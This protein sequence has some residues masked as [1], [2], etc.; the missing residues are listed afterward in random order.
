MGYVFKRQKGSHIILVNHEKRK[1][2]VV[3]NRK[4][5]PRGT[6]KAIIRESGLTKEEFLKLI[7]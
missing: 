4:E 6:F 5:I 3:P 1:V 2:A 7:D